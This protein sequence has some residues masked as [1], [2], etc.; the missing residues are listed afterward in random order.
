MAKNK[1][2]SRFPNFARWMANAAGKPATFAIA[3]FIVIIWAVTG[4]LF[5]YSD[6]WQLV[7]NTGTTIVTFL[8][9]GVPYSKYPKPGHSGVATQA[10][11]IDTSHKR[12]A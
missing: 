10:G 2:P 9:N 6:T 12:R 4:P 8:Y 5:A 1:S 7:I 11:R 3:L